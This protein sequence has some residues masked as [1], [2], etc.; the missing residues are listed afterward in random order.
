MK[1]DEK[2]PASLRSKQWITD[3]LLQLMEKKKYEDITITNICNHAQLARRTFYRHFESKE[4]VIDKLVERVVQEFIDCMQGTSLL[5]FR[6]YITTY[7]RFWHE[8]MQLLLL[9][10]K[11]S[12]L[13]VLAIEYIKRFSEVLYLNTKD[14]DSSNLNLIW[15]FC[16]GGLWSLLVYWITVDSTKTAD[17]ISDTLF[18]YVQFK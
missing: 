15:A 9:L 14:M 17:E 3:S 7:Y 6:T 18:S 13:D 16:S 4:E 12:L 5:D 11:D 8:H 2:H 1:K 10:N